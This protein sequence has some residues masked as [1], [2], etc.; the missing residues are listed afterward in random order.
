[1]VSQRPSARHA[2]KLAHAQGPGG[3][4]VEVWKSLRGWR[5]TVWASN[6][7]VVGACEEGFF[8]RWNAT[9][10]VAAAHPAHLTV[11]V[12][13]GR[14]RLGYHVTTAGALR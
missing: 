9:Q 10:R 13:D 2:R 6:G 14:L 4:V 3:R 1:M 7:Q 12:S 5:Y 11:V 8:R